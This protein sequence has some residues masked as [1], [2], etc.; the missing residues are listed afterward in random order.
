MIADRGATQR[1]QHVDAAGPSA[2]DR[3]TQKVTVIGDD[4]KIEHLC[5]I[6]TRKGRNPECVRTDDLARTGLAAGRYQLV[7]GREDRDTRPPIDGASRGSWLRKREMPIV[8]PDTGGECGIALGEVL[9][10]R[11]DMSSGT[12]RKGRAD[13]PIVE[14]LCIFLQENAVGTRGN[15]GPSEDADSLSGSHLAGI[16]MPRR[17][18]S[19]DRQD[20][21][22]S[23]ASDARRA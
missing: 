1:H 7:P 20:R 10:P 23:A 21:S 6:V 16:A 13:A 22:D 3:L 14:F 11:P 2:L 8:E 19:D 4:P 5:S 18:F 15:G 17:R 9:P 12:H